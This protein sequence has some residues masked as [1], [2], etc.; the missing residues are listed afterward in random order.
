V[1][2]S[3]FWRTFAL[4]ALVVVAS[5]L[6]WFR[7]FRT[8]ERQPRAERLA[9]EVASVVNLTRAGLLS[10]SPASRPGLLADLA[11]DEGVRVVP[12]EP[13]DR[14]VPLANEAIAARAEAKLREMLGEQAALAGSVN[15]VDGLWA[16]FDIDG[17]PYWLWLDP[18]RLDRQDG[19]EWLAWLGLAL[20]LALPGAFA[21]SRVVNR[22]L[23]GLAAA[24]DRVSR[25]ET[26]PPL[27]ESAPSEIAEVNRRFNRMAA[28]LA[29]LD[30]DRTE[31]L[32]GISHDIRTP[33]TRLR[34]E[35][36]LS[37]L[38]QADKD[39]MGD[40][41]ARIDAIVGQFIEYARPLDPADARQVDVA[42][43]L[44]EVAGRH[45]PMSAAPGAPQPDQTLD[46]GLGLTIH[47]APG[48]QW[49]GQ[50]T[51]LARI[52]DNL[53]ENARRYG[54][55]PGTG[56]AEV[57]V[58]AAREGAALVLQVRDRGPGVP[59][60]QLERLPRPFTRLDAARS[61][62]GGSGLGLAIVSRLARRYGGALVL[63]QAPG[64]GLLARVRLP[65]ASPPG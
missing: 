46:P 20:L 30:A 48:A 5:L 40:E 2:V 8:A 19:R 43:L 53:L 49:R 55:T 1:R 51:V 42:T 45:P 47:V 18:S 11:R 62:D 16:R 6:A 37:G 14:S 21:I 23:A 64:G 28:D 50:P 39:S 56:R 54:A 17:D 57:E 41:I 65:D 9:W 44:A 24:I 29:A 3:L 32:A 58:R 52:L 38:P 36:E 59:D 31:A 63:E 61:R 12:L 60:E 7:L 34:M 13:G 33:L 10:A 27:A 15:G 4:I 35:I 25:G 26:A 22:P